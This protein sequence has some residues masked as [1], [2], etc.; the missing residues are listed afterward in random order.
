MWDMTMYMI[1]INT[2]LVDLE[3]GELLGSS[4]SYRTSLARKPSAAMVAR[5]SIRSSPPN[6]REL[7]R[8]SDLQSKTS[9]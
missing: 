5:F 4:E 8:L 6:S 1:R 2:R 9:Q 7:W 3:T